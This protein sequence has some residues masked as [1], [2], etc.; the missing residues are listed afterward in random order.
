MAISPA[1]G[2]GL[3]LAIGAAHLSEV[4]PGPVTS[5]APFRGQ[6]AAL[7]RALGGAALPSPGRVQRMNEGRLVWSGPGRAILVGVPV[8]EGLSELAAVVEQGDGLACLRLEGL[9][10]REVLARLVPIDLRDGAFPEGATA[11]TLLNH[12]AVTLIRIEPRAY[13]IFAMRSMARTLVHEL[14]EAMRRVAARQGAV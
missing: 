3:P 4:D 7:S 11:R 2:L 10:A 5:I 8:P 1:Q 9:A 13:E 12:L 6:E 14:D